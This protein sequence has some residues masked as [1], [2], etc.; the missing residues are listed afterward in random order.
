V[1]FFVPG[2]Q[3][4]AVVAGFGAVF[5]NVA[6]PA[7]SSLEFFT[8]EGASLGK[9][10]VR[11]APHGLSFL[12]VIFTEKVVAR[13]RVTQGTA[14][15]GEIDNPAQGDNVVVMDDFLYSEPVQRETSRGGY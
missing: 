13:V 1:E 4:R 14:E 6:I 11:V 2:T 7:T 5:T 9:F 8:A 15:V 10:F 12:G 3:D